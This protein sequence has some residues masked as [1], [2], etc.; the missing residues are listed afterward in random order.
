[1]FTTAYD[2]IHNGT[3][4]IR[5]WSSGYHVFDCVRGGALTQESGDWVL[6]DSRAEGVL[7]RSLRD[8]DTIVRLKGVL[9]ADF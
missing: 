1:M 2:D 3:Y 7:G 5:H 4:I 9:V 6:N 8:I